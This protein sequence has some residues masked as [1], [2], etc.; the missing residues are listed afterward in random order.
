M[1]DVLTSITIAAPPGRVWAVLTDFAAYPQWN[2][3]ISKVRAEPR[4]GATIRFRIKLEA[5]PTLRFA[6]R[7]RLPGDIGADEVRRRSE[8]ARP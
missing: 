5:T 8:R 4:E 7:L 2:Q 3:V 6:A 1:T